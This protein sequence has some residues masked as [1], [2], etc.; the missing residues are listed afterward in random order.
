[1]PGNVEILTAVLSIAGA[2]TLG[3]MSPGPSFLMVARAAIARSRADGVAAALGMGVGGV[4]FAAAALL[5]LHVVLIA[6]PWLYLVLKILGGAYLIFIGIL[7]WRGARAPVAVVTNEE[8]HGHGRTLLSSFWL[9]LL[10]QISNPK[11]AVVY[12][13]VFVA[14]LPREIPWWATLV[15][16]VVIFVIEAG[17]YAIVALALSAPSPR[18]AYLRSKTWIDRAAGTVM[19]LL[20]VR[21][22]LASK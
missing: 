20:G 21:L 3:A 5:G 18:A 1:L 13:S 11:A 7:I 4:L 17:W 22:I 10:T 16:P 12:A 14:L 6:V 15:L 8:L 2:I 9:A 19:A